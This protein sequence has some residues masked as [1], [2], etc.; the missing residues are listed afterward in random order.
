MGTPLVNIGLNL[1]LANI[2]KIHTVDKNNS[3]LYNV[4]SNISYICTKKFNV[5]LT[6][7]LVWKKIRIFKT[8]T[9]MRPQMT[10]YR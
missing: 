7:L 6:P 4:A 8:G 9:E 5:F 10:K 2:E 3:H 1:G